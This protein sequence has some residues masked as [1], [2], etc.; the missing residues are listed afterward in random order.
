LEGG[1][2]F[3]LPRYKI[4]PEDDDPVSLPDF[5]NR[6]LWDHSWIEND[7]DFEEATKI[8]GLNEV[9]ELKIQIENEDTK[10]KEESK[11]EDDPNQQIPMRTSN[12]KIRNNQIQEAE[13]RNIHQQFKRQY[14]N[15]NQGKRWEKKRR[16][17]K[18]PKISNREPIPLDQITTVN[19]KRT[20]TE[21][22]T[23]T[24]DQA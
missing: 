17:L 16:K 9:G 5:K 8:L 18:K 4:H 24:K 13:R 15:S 2:S 14:K 20:R 19:R 11:S 21:M 23:E 12:K 6:W 1:D 22:E 10:D 7:D 3:L